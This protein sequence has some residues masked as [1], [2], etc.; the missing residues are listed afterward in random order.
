MPKDAH[1]FDKEVIK[2][3]AHTNILNAAKHLLIT[4]VNYR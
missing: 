2:K 4:N 1:A 3:N